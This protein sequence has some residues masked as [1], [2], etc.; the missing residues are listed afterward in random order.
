MTRRRL[1]TGE[2]HGIE[3]ST[4]YFGECAYIVFLIQY[5]DHMAG[6]TYTPVSSAKSENDHPKPDQPQ[7]IPDVDHTRPHPGP[8]C[9]RCT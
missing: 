8:K 4:Q 3:I 5:S 2:C 7:M 6:T 1:T 9:Y